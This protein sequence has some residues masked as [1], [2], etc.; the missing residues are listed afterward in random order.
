MWNV[1]AE[2]GLHRIVCAGDLG[3]LNNISKYGKNINLEE[4]FNDEVD[5]VISENLQIVRNFPDADYVLLCGNHDNRIFKHLARKC[6]EFRRYISIEK[7]YMLD[8]VG[9][10]HYHFGPNQ[11][12]RVGD[13]FI[14]HRFPGALNTAP[15]RAGCNIIYGDSHK[16][17]HAKYR[18]VDGR[19][20]EAINCGWLGSYKSPAFDYIETWQQWQHG[21]V[22]ITEH[23]GK[24]SAQMIEIHHDENKY[25]CFAFG[26]CYEISAR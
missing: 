16:L 2:I 9:I 6:P 4:T 20:I 23:N 17:G 26:R 8:S 7:L 18:C 14:R 5:A 21:F 10:K 19:I 3:D 15:Q 25:W 1:G 11:G 12:Y 13:Y 22:I 24:S